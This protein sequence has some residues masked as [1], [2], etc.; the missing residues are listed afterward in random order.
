M[1]NIRTYCIGLL[2]KTW[3]YS[4]DQNWTMYQKT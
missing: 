1:T 4:T 2:K 3:R